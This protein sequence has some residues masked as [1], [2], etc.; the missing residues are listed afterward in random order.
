M[1]VRQRARLKDPS[2]FGAPGALTFEKHLRIHAQEK[3]RYF[4]EVASLPEDVREMRIDPGYV[5][6]M[7]SRPERT[8][9][10]RAPRRRRMSSGPCSSCPHPRPHS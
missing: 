5:D 8:S 7:H 3:Q 2:R 6:A 10:D 4:E 9:L 1:A